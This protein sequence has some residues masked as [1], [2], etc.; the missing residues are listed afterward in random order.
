MTTEVL[1]ELLRV[2]SDGVV[3]FLVW[4][5]MKQN[6]KLIAEVNSRDNELMKLIYKILSTEQPGTRSKRDRTSRIN[7][8]RAESK[9]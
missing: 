8:P 3:I 2:G 7:R 9:E 1:P 6:Q 4:S 5:L